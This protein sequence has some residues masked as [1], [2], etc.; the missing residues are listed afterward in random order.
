M[1]TNQQYTDRGQN[2]LSAFE[3]SRQVTDWS[4]TYTVALGIKGYCM[5]WQKIVL[6]MF[7]TWEVMCWEV[8]GIM[9]VK[10]VIWEIHSLVQH[11]KWTFNGNK[12][13]P[14][15]QMWDILKICLHDDKI[16]HSKPKRSRLT[17][18]HKHNHSP[19]PTDGG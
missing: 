17:H 3:P 11:V 12:S 7:H 2:T 18:S 8:N 19:E 1:K 10:W 15:T 14:S 6:M 4:W 9:N 16:T 13:S 5:H